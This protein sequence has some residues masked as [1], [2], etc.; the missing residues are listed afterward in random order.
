MLS[1]AALEYHRNKVYMKIT[2]QRLRDA[3]DPF[4]MPDERFREMYRLPRCL[5]LEFLRILSD[6]ISDNN[7]CPDVPLTI[8]FCAALGADGFAFVS[9]TVTSRCVRHI[10]Y[11]IAN[12]MV[13]EFIR[14]PRSKKEIETLHDEMQSYADFPGAFAILDGSHI[15]LTSLK[16]QDEFALSWMFECVF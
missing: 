6:H 13:G 9:Q 1:L 15:A 12:R 3:L 2:R 7:L 5:A 14:F 11:I 10:S 8:Q 16:K 4:D